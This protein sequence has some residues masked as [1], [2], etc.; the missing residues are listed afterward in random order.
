MTRK[1]WIESLRVLAAAAVVMTHVV[2]GTYD[3]P[4]I[5][6]GIF[7][8]SRGREILDLVF[9]R[10][11]TVWAVPVFLMISG[12][13]L[14]D[15]RKELTL[16]KIKEYVWRMAAVLLTFG[17]VFCLIESCL[18]SPKRG[19]FSVIGMSVWN[20]IQGK[21]WEHLWYVYMM[22][23]L[24][25]MTPILRSFFKTEN[26]YAQSMVMAALFLFTIVVPTC[27]HLFRWKIVNILPVDSS[28]LYYYMLGHYL[29]QKEIPRKKNLGYMAGAFSVL[30]VLSFWKTEELRHVLNYENLFVMVFSASIFCFA[31]KS[32]WMEQMGQKKQI[33][34]L[35]GLSFGIYI[36]HPV[37][38]NILNK[39]FH[40]YPVDFPWIAGEVGFAA[41]VFLCSA[42]LVMLL[43]RVR[44]I[45]NII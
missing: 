26:R 15:P 27:N 42:I 40:I 7:A 16:R 19:V 29:G 38:L 45:K 37:F 14:L 3:S 2:S 4:D 1:G 8:V 31:M 12:Y 6:T 13:L 34:T 20:L 35:A 25:L 43:K 5:G 32:L 28:S 30:C 33:Q 39:G 18:G 44:L 36:I 10:S 22:A 11:L 17:L 9:F 21:S 23:G 41:A 24:Y